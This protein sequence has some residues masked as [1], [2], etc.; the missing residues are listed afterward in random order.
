MHIAIVGGFCRK[1]LQG[2]AFLPPGE[3]RRTD[4]M[5]HCVCVCVCVYLYTIRR[6]TMM[7]MFICIFN[8]MYV[9]NMYLHIR[10]C[11]MTCM[12]NCVYI[13]YIFIYIYVLCIAFPCI[14]TYVFYLSWNKDTVMQY[15]ILCVYV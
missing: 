12:F 13:L 2:S 15:L 8:C 14:E 9:Y 11:T 3:Q 7:C 1:S 10:R 6:Y 5:F 4:A